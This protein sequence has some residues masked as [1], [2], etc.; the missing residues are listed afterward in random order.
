MCLIVG[1]CLRFLRYDLGLLE[2]MMLGLRMLLGLSSVLI[3]YIMLVRV[4]L[5]W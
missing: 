4:F 5:Y 2:S 1:M 3:F